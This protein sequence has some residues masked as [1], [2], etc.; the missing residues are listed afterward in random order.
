MPSSFQQGAIQRFTAQPWTR[1]PNI[2]DLIWPAWRYTLTDTGSVITTL[3]PAKG[4]NVYAGA[5]IADN[6]L[7]GKGAYN[8]QIQTPGLIRCD[9]LAAYPSGNNR[10]WSSFFAGSIPRTTNSGLWY[11]WSY[12]RTGGIGLTSQIQLQGS[13]TVNQDFRLIVKNDAGILGAFSSLVSPGRNSFAYGTICDGT[14]MTTVFNNVIVDNAIPWNPGITTVDEFGIG[15]SIT[16]TGV[17]LPNVCVYATAPL[18]WDLQADLMPMM[19]WA[20]RYMRIT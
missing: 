7:G 17:S 9:A 10:P 3:S 15:E 4:S 16:T 13:G 12:T 18:A 19:T 2:T 14:T 20:M 6:N 5:P 1:N 8:A 11:V